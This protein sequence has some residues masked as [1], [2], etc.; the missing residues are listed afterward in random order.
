M[1]TQ[2]NRRAL[3]DDDMQQTAPLE[4]M[5]RTGANAS[6]RPELMATNTGVRLACTMS[7][8]I[9]LLAIFLCWA[10]HDSRVIRRFSVQSAALTAVHAVL[11]I[12]LLLVGSLL[13]SI[14]YFGLMIVLGSW[15]IYIAGLLVLLALRVRLM[16]HA[17]HGERYDLPLIEGRLTKF[18]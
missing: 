17:W 1:S 2:R 16:E 5:G 18:Y 13:G 15:L 7:A 9:G 11:A 3:R 12:V 6:L 10:E 4:P 14:P 8:M